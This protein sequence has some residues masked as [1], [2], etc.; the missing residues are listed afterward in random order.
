MNH[1]YYSNIN[2][3]KFD[4]DYIV[5]GFIIYSS[6]NIKPFL[7]VALDSTTVQ[8]VFH[9]QMMCWLCRSVD[10]TDGQTGPV[11]FIMILK[12]RNVPIPL[13]LDY[14]IWIWIENVILNYHTKSDLKCYK[15]TLTITII[16]WWWKS[17]QYDRKH[18]STVEN[19]SNS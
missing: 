16:K 18:I 3:N 7:N 9:Y 4:S 12:C 2:K 10:M 19:I 6:F 1:Y 8:L 15:L 17:L 11:C 14:F 5:L 13:I